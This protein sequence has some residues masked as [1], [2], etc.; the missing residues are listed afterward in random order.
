TLAYTITE[1]AQEATEYL[2]VSIVSNN[3]QSADVAINVAIAGYT[4]EGVE[5]EENEYLYYTLDNDGNRIYLLYED[6]NNDPSRTV[7]LNGLDI[8]SA[9]NAWSSVAVIRNEELL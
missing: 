8:L 3:E 6:R 1:S 2:V 5:G 7:L 4:S 9:Q